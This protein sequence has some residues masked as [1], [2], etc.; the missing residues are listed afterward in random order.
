MPGGPT[1]RGAKLFQEPGRPTTKR[2][3]GSNGNWPLSP[4][5]GMFYKKRPR[6]HGEGCGKHRMARLM[7]QAGLRGIPAPRHWKRRKSRARPA[8]ITNQLVRDF[9][10][11]APNAKWVTDI[12]Y[13]ATQEGWLYL[14]V[15]LDLFSPQVIGWSMQPQLTRDL[16]MQAVLIA[17]RQRRNR[18]PV[19]L[20]SDRG[21]QYTS[22]E[23]HLR[24]ST[25]I[26]LPFLMPS[27]YLCPSLTVIFKISFELTCSGKSIS[28]L[29]KIS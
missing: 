24:T 11:T 20:H 21:T 8:G 18:E 13:N 26:G 7:W 16:V 2:W 4:G 5:S 14:A 22:Q 9:T 29:N 23:F 28:L 19:L 10:A 12:M 17:V 3:L 25:N 15:V 27:L 6:Q 1:A